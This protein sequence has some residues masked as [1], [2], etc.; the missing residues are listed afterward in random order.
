MGDTVGLN[1]DSADCM[2]D[3]SAQDLDFLGLA[4]LVHQDLHQDRTSDASLP[5]DGRDL[6]L[7]DLEVHGLRVDL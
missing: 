3:A 4:V 7:D 1:V 2:P 6:G 5:G